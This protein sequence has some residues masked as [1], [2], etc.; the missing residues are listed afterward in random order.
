MSG[1]GERQQGRREGRG[2]R[3]RTEVDA[4]HD[5]GKDRIA[6]VLANDGERR[7][8]GSEATDRKARAAKMIKVSEG[9]EVRKGR[10][11]TIPS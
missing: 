1:R 11:L 4:G 2:R 8:E 3:G 6:T 9:K 7:T 5:G 10:G